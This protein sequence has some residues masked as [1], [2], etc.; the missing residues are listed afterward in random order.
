M[1]TDTSAL[2]DKVRVSVLEKNKSNFAT[3]VR[4]LIVRLN[5][6]DGTTFI[7][8]LMEKEFADFR[9][10]L[11]N[12]K[13]LVLIITTH[14]KAINRERTFSNR[15]R[16]LAKTIFEK[17]R[18]PLIEKLKTLKKE[19]QHKLKKKEKTIKTKTRTT[20]DEVTKHENTIWNA[21]KSA[22]K[23]F[24]SQA[25][26]AKAD[27][28]AQAE[29]AKA[30]AEAG[31]GERQG[32]AGEEEV[33]EV[34]VEEE[35]GSNRM[36]EDRKEG[37]SKKF[38]VN[39][40]KANRDGVCQEFSPCEAAMLQKDITNWYKNGN[41]DSKSISKLSE[42]LKHKQFL[43]FHSGLLEA[44]K[45]D[46]LNI[47]LMKYGPEWKVGYEEFSSTENIQVKGEFDKYFYLRTDEVYEYKYTDMSIHVV[48]KDGK[49]MAI[50]WLFSDLAHLFGGARRQENKVG[51]EYSQ[52]LKLV[53]NF[54]KEVV[55]IEFACDTPGTDRDQ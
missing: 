15:L 43:D 30:D 41:F 28:E 45:N 20:L 54:N 32:E 26:V 55:S 1:P 53:F 12:D 13:P 35:G 21:V 39:Y 51:I 50:P 2:W 52:L 19:Y 36:D 24:L 40:I 46:T 37:E 8:D 3:H 49:L 7:K 44:I 18:K 34:E 33:V 22:Y 27:A 31:K 48:D 11:D 5:S 6:E 16:E 17:K 23:K 10:R 4:E 9:S 14:G 38:K 29:V 25:E 42:D 47:Y